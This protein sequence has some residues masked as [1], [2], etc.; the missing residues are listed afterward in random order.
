[1]KKNKINSANIFKRLRVIVFVATILFCFFC[2]MACSS[3]EEE[4]STHISEY[5]DNYY[6]GIANDIT[7]DFCDGKREEPFCMDGIANPLVEYGVLT[8]RSK[9]NL[10]ENVSYALQ[11][12]EKKFEGIFEIRPFDNSYIAD[13]ESLCDEE[14]FVIL[15]IGDI[16]IK[17]D[18]L[19]K[20]FSINSS[21]ALTKFAKI[22]KDQL[23]SYMNKDFT[24]E[25]FVKVVSDRQDP[26]SICFFV[27]SKGQ[28]GEV[29]GT[30]FD[31]NTGEVLQQ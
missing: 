21:K 15:K 16:E 20:N 14:E 26:N 5:V 4:V 17:L 2:T 6:M 31:A 19:S 25:V 23:K 22:H 30:L 8:V 9:K 10:G 12:G 28:N 1:M 27:V 29:I 11:I 7:A 13:I 18:N 3:V 24:A